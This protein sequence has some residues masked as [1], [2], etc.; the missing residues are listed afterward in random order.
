VVCSASGLFFTQTSSSYIRRS[1][2][3]ERNAFAAALHSSWVSLPWVVVHFAVFAGRDVEPGPIGPT[4]AVQLSSA[5]TEYGIE[6]HISPGSR[7]YRAMW[8]GP[9]SCE[10]SEISPTSSAIAELP[11]SSFISGRI[12]WVRSSTRNQSSCS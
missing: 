2:F 6:D 3:E 1:N 11:Y 10:V 9:R 12:S 7:E 5:S 4:P 8:C